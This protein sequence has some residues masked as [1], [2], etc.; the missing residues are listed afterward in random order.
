MLFQGFAFETG[1]EVACRSWAFLFVCVSEQRCK[2]HPRDSVESVRFNSYS[3]G[4]S[5]WPA[6][7]SQFVPDL[8]SSAVI[9][10]VVGFAIYRWQKRSES[11]QAELA[12]LASWS[13]SRS[14]VTVAISEDA[15]KRAPLDPKRDNPF[16]AVQTVLEVLPVAIW[17]ASAPK[18]RE[19]QLVNVIAIDLPFF[20]E[21]AAKLVSVV[22]TALILIDSSSLFSP[23][24]D[25]L[26]DA[27]LRTL[28][29][30][31]SEMSS[32]MGIFA[33][34]LGGKD[35]TDRYLKLNATAKEASETEAVVTANAHYYEV[36][37][38]LA[39]L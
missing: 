31:G 15:P 9:G 24:S 10:F 20:E 19:L 14:R 26:R 13:V 39:E 28:G 37:E 18:N 35:E 11:R 17:S 32:F 2:G 38:R 34:F 3:V 7:W 30:M 12:T 5:I 25:Y 29:G 22:D 16:L 36:Y 21:A 27:T 8:V 33:N 23:D 4:V 6:N 1:A